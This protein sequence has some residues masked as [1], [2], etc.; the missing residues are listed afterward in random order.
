MV[1][2]L[3]GNQLDVQT[4]NNDTFYKPIVWSLQ[5]YIFAD[6]SPGAKLFWGYAFDEF[7]QA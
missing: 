5:C 2:F 7:F 4:Q 6:K 3:P 1:G